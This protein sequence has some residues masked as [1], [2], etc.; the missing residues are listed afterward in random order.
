MLAVKVPVTSTFSA[1]IVA[2]IA[3]QPEKV[4]PSL[5]GAA[6]GIIAAPYSTSTV[7]YSVPSTL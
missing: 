3:L 5:V 4:W 7:L 6:S 1:G 2:G